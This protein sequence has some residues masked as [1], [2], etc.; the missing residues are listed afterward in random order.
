MYSKNWR[1]NKNYIYQ[2][3]TEVSVFTGKR[4]KL[5]KSSLR[6]CEKKIAINKFTGKITT[7]IIF[8]DGRIFIGEDVWRM[9]NRADFCE[10]RFISYPTVKAALISYDIQEAPRSILAI[11]RRNPQYH[12]LP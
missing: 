9:S 5:P 2:K 11:E 6:P 4:R 3:D 1:K 10:Y 7:A 8:P 12:E